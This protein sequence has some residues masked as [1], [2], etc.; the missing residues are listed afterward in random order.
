MKQGRNRIN[1]RLGK[2]VEPRLS[3]YATRYE[4]ERKQ[5]AAGFDTEIIMKD[6]ISQFKIEGSSVAGHSAV[7]INGEWFVRPANPIEA[8]YLETT[9]RDRG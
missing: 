9:W 5:D 3:Y 6:G 1:N 7:C 4:L 2:P 8:R